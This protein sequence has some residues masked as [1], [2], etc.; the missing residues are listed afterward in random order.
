MYPISGKTLVNIAA[1]TS[2]PAKEGASLDESV[3]RE[4]TKEEMMNAYVGWDPE[5]T[6][7]LSVSQA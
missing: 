7:L 1:F 6:T 2:D 4:A 3:F 5:V